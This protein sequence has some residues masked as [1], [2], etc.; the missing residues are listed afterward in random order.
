M[1]AQFV[2][3]TCL[4]QDGLMK[5]YGDLVMIIHTTFEISTNFYTLAKPQTY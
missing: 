1:F 4:P 5:W 3:L 2:K